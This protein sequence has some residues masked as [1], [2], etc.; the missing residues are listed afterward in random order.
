MHI[1]ERDAWPYWPLIRVGESRN[2]EGGWDKCFGSLPL[3]FFLM[4]LLGKRGRGHS[5]LSNYVS[6]QERGVIVW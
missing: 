4:Y 5:L 2:E 6:S 3:S 1:L